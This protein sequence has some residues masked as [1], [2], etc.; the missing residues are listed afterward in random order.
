MP[1]GYHF[2]R[3]RWYDANEADKEIAGLKCELNDALD[4]AK[5]SRE[6]ITELQGAKAQAEVDAAFWKKKYKDL[7]LA[8]MSI[9]DKEEMAK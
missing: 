5:S 8:L 1:T 6:M 2:N 7:Q 3:K 9:V 4:D